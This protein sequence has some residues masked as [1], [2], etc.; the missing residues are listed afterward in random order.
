MSYLQLDTASS[1][2]ILVKEMSNPS[3]KIYIEIV[4][5]VPFYFASKPYFSLPVKP[6]TRFTLFVNTCFSQF[7]GV[8]E[9]NLKLTLGKNG[10]DPSWIR[11]QLVKLLKLFQGKIFHQLFQVKG[12][13]LWRSWHSL[14]WTKGRDQSVSKFSDPAYFWI[15][16]MVKLDH[17]GQ[18]L[19]KLLC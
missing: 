14:I 2:M 17:C 4:F 3:L 7:D 18:A 1:V 10:N 5:Q 12:H 9:K 13:L 11:D 8:I 19:K 16:T 6:L 15:Y